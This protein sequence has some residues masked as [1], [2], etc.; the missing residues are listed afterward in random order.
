MDEAIVNAKEAVEL[1][2]ESLIAH[3]ERIPIY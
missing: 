1:F 3:G 2:L